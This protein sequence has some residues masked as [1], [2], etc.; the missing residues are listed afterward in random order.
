MSAARCAALAGLAA[1]L[2][3]ML[4]ATLDHPAGA[5]ARPRAVPA[6][7]ASAPPP[8]WAT[9]AT[10]FSASSPWNSRPLDPLL[11]PVTI[12]AAGQ[13]PM[14]E[15]G[16]W[17]TGVFV[18]A[19]A[20]GPMTVSGPPG[21]AGLWNPDSGVH[22]DVVV[23]RWPP[24]VAPAAQS[25]GHADIVD[26][27]AGIIHSFYQ[28][29]READRWVATQYAWSRLGGRGWGDPAHSFQ[30]SRA[31]GVP[32]MGG[33]I[34]TAEV[35]DGALFYRHALAISLERTALA[36]DPPYVY[37]A[38]SA[39]T[40]ART[41]NSG[42]IPQG[43]LLMLPPAFDVDRIADARL[44]KVARTLMRYGAYVVD[45]NDGAPF[46]IYAEIGSSLQLH[47][48]GWDQQAADDLQAMRQALHR[49][50]GARLWNDGNEVAMT[51]PDTFNLLSMR[52]PWIGPDGR[53][54]RFDSA[55]QVLTL[56]AAGA[57]L[58]AHRHLPPALTEVAWARPAAGL[59]YRL[60]SSATGA[61]TIE[62]IW[63]DP[64]SG[65]SVLRSGPLRHGEQFSFLWPGGAPAVLLV[66]R[67]TGTHAASAA[68]DLRRAPR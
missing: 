17:S 65:R 55:S 12:A 33:L 10:P 23:P 15:S 53:A 38:T 51:G 22:A 39:D 42:A 46:V 60:S 3:L 44:R 41:I 14:I 56:P 30:G 52:G 26:P 34:R 28:L 8:V 64:E 21:S 36:A 66:V 1:L 5:A 13:A 40:G 31:A 27:V 59:P 2:V 16:P 43:A 4:A 50:I 18:A 48:Q 29:R 62:L 35:D 57:P 61:A 49:V 45:R 47:A 32:A 54:V 11:V 19:A 7:M 68:A 20:A 63:T 24:A 6:A 9:P 58:E 37:P 67:S 25:D